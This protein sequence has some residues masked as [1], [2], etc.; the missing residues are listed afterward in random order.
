MDPRC[1]RIMLCALV[2]AYSFPVLLFQSFAITCFLPVFRLCLKSMRTNSSHHGIVQ[3]FLPLC[4]FFKR[5]IWTW[6]KVRRRKTF[7][8]LYNNLFFPCSSSLKEKVILLLTTFSKHHIY[9]YIYVFG[10]K[11][12]D[13]FFRLKGQRKPSF[14]LAKK[15]EFYCN[16]WHWILY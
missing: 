10:K 8:F 16:N 13:F 2:H 1:S 12:N 15:I 9:I 7:S 5:L 4:I 14:Y 3:W 6:R 11:R